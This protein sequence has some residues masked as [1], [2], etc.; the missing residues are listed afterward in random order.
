MKRILFAIPTEGGLHG[1]SAA[2][3]S[4]L[5][6]RH[7]GQL[8]F[9][10]V[11]GRPVDFVRNAIVRQFLA[12]DYQYL[13]LMDSDIVPPPDVLDLLLHWSESRDA[14]LVGGCYPVLGEG[15]YLRWALAH[16]GTDGHYRLIRDLPDTELPFAVDAAGAGCLLIRRDVF[17]HTKWPWFKW[18][19]NE[20][21]SQIS[22][23]I[24]FFSQCND[25]GLQLLVDP[26]IICEHQKSLNLTSLM[27]ARMSKQ[28]KETPPCG[29][30]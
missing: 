2:A 10:V 23:D 12:H 17:T 18:V 22:E 27:R 20:D 30:A 24:S 26:T 9:I 15:G 4:L 25:A 13:F 8:D 16:R 29:S 7:S 14:P 28:T 21:G 11:T 5:N 1:L 6:Q 19:E 3:A